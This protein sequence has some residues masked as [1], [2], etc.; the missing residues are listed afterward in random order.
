V[1]ACGLDKR[2]G[3][4]AHWVLAWARSLG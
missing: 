3:S 1:A 2:G 4:A